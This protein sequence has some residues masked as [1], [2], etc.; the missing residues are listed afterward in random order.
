LKPGTTKADIKKTCEEAI[1]YKFPAV[2][3]PPSFIKDAKLYLKDS[4]VKIATVIGF[5]FGYSSTETKVFETQ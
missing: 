3:I 2:C 1:Q 4:K 5:P